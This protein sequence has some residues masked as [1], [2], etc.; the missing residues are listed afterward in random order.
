M[1]PC[2]SVHVQYKGPNHKTRAQLKE[3]LKQLSQFVDG[4]TIDTVKQ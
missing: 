3:K 1:R 4:T 2:T